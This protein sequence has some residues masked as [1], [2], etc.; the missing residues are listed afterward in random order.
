[1]LTSIWRT[2]LLYQG[3]L[4]HEYAG[5]DSVR[6]GGPGA[7]VEL[8]SLLRY[9]KLCMYFSK[10]P[11]KVFLEFGGFDQS[12]VLIKKSKARVRKY[13]STLHFL[14]YVLWFYY[15]LYLTCWTDNF[16]V[17]FS[18]DYKSG[19][20]GWNYVLLCSFWSLLSQLS[21]IETPN[22]FS[23][24]FGGLLVLRKGWQQQLE[25]TFHFIMLWLKMAVYPT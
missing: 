9:M 12:D 8:I 17:L 23:F 21:V 16:S 19:Q 15:I 7:R 6:L 22:A 25:Q 20:I 13:Q 10:K 3:N 11:Y 2:V 24:S 18:T 14:H 4:Q 5:S 1:M